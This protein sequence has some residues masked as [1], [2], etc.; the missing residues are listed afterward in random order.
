MDMDVTPSPSFRVPELVARHTKVPGKVSVGDWAEV[1]LGPGLL[2]FLM[3]ARGAGAPPGRGTHP[4]TGVPL[5][6]GIEAAIQA[7]S[8]KENGIDVLRA[9]ECVLE[10]P[11]SAGEVLR[12][13]GEVVSLG[14]RCVRA[15]L[16]VYGEL[17]DCSESTNRL[18]LKGEVI[19]VR[20]V[21]G[22]AVRLDSLVHLD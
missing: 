19:L 18:L 15:H 2:E 5:G 14:R 11:V 6:V 16:K 17:T 21:E 22:K 8:G 12:A 7:A 10:S 4:M 20:V 13:R 3:T 1:R 9:C